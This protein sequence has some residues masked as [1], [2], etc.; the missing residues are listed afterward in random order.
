MLPRQFDS[1]ASKGV[2]INRREPQIFGCAWDPPPCGTGVANPLEVSPSHLCY[3]AEYGRSRSKVTSVIKEIRLKTTPCVPPFK[4]T[5]GHRLTQIDPRYDFL[6][7][8]HS[9]HGPISY[10]FRDKRQFQSEIANIPHPVYLTELVCL[11]IGYRSSG[12]K[13]YNDEATG[14]IKKFDDIFSRM[15]TI[16]ER[17]GQTDRRT[18]DDSKDRAY[19]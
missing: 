6:L 8:F 2:C 1:S 11:G 19:A 15:D 4:A 16:Y 14:T 3:P 12:W 7:T 18:L 10:R 13:N 5:Q 9:N 17:D